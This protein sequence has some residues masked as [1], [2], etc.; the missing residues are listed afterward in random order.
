MKGETE[1]KHGRSNQPA[2]ALTYYEDTAAQHLPSLASAPSI[3]CVRTEYKPTSAQK[4]TS[5]AA[6]RGVKRSSPSKQQLSGRLQLKR[7]SVRITKL[8]CDAELPRARRTLVPDIG[9]GNG[10]EAFR[11]SDHL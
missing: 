5:T 9:H 4:C 7:T 8:L 6:R 1:P 10:T 11:T 2:Y 3:C